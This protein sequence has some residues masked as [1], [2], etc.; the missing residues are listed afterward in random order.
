[1]KRIQ[2]ILLALVLLVSY[3]QA[4]SQNKI[5]VQGTV[6]DS[7]GNGL[8]YVTISLL[9][10]KD[11]MLIKAAASDENGKFEIIVN[12]PGN[13]MASYSAVGYEMA[14]SVLFN[15]SAGQTLHIPDVTLRVSSKQLQ[16]VI[17]SSRKPLIQIKADKTVFNVQNS[18]NAT[19][20]NAL[21]LLE[22][23]PGIMVDNNDNISM[24][25]KAGVKIFIDGKM[26]QL[27]AEDLAAY[28]KSINS[29]D[30]EA[31]EM[32]NNPGAKYDAS[33]N[34][35]VINIRLKKNTSLGTNGSVTLGLIQGIT[36]KGN[37]ALNINK[38]GKKFNIFSNVS[39]S[40]GRNETNIKAPRVQKDT[41]YDQR[42][43]L[44]SSTTNYNIKAGADYFVSKKQTLGLMASSGFNNEDYISNGVTQIFYQP[45]YEYQK[46]LVATNAIPR[47]RTNINTNI[48]YR[49]SDTAGR[50]INFD[51]DYGLFRGRAKSYQPNYYIDKNE[52]LISEIIT[53]NNTPTD[54]DIYTVKLD[55]GIPKW[56][57]SFGFGGKLSFVK[58]NNKFD[59][60]NENNG[61]S[62]IVQNR[63]YSFVYKENVN[64][65]YINYQKKI[66]E[67]WSFHAGV[68]M[69]QTNSK[70]SLARGDGLVQADSK[71]KRSYLDFFPNV[72][73]AW[74]IDEN[75]ALNLSY[76]R[77]ID[78]PNYQNLNPF[79]MKLDELTY[80]KGNS[81]L[82]PQYTSNIELAHTWKSK[83]VTSISFSHVNDY[84]T[85][86][87]D[88]L[89]NFTFVQQKN[90]A[91]QN[92][93]NFSISSPVTI[94]KCW[95]GF[96]SG[97]FNY[98]I[99]K[100]IISQKPVYIKV[101]G[102]GVSFQNTFTLAKNYSAELTGWF[103]G[104]SANGPAWRSKTIGTVDI[105]FQKLMF[106]K[107]ATL[108]FGVTD[109]FHTSSKYRAS[110]DF[111]GLLLNI[112]VKR[113]AQTARLNFTY[114]FGNSKVKAAR[115]RQTG[116]ETESKRISEN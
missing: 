101:P 91:T 79:E 61:I 90:L 14:F 102:Y 59:F 17:V 110:S 114:R 68:R 27:T 82:R 76:G 38:R 74:T 84:S 21:E 93:F 18:I 2:M 85:S 104:P 62:V 58:T 13:Y 47:R 28:L 16:D 105:G 41:L 33:G 97:W 75:N 86:T 55:I 53:R 48:N 12:E 46:K 116:L 106:E 31:I 51:S 42:L 24:K 83:M 88:T 57:G 6:N 44:V 39:V 71:V 36:P 26:I 99:F 11:S 10:S 4:L 111:G 78:R 94:S 29:N 98:Q 87:T 81:F 115:Q 45:T 92:I 80:V 35:G 5:F 89:N 9:K 22:K 25:G 52:V 43:L 95:K 30:I 67:A 32:I 113:E 49:Y 20:S 65:A 112:W 40:N 7:K 64:A 1:M 8:K 109:I 50:E 34:A 56:K 107:K 60:F 15:L 66:T 19:G 77:R 3:N 72:S 73:V 69:E 37:G 54:I 96:V 108:K 103:R 100:G 23:S 70:G 63:S